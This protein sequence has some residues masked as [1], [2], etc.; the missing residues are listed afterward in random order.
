MPHGTPEQDLSKNLARILRYEVQKHN[1]T[2][3]PGGWIQVHELMQK[4]GVGPRA[5]RDEVIHVAKTS[6]G[7]HG[8]RFDLEEPAKGFF[9]IRARYVHGKRG[10]GGMGGKGGKGGQGG[11][12]ETFPKQ[13]SS[14]SFYGSMPP[15]P[16]QTR[17]YTHTTKVDHQDWQTSAQQMPEIP[18]CGSNSA[19]ASA[20]CGPVET[21]HPWRDSQDAP[22]APTAPPVGQLG[23]DITTRP[24]SG[25]QSFDISTPRCIQDTS[26]KPYKDPTTGRTWYFNSK[27]EEFFFA[28]TAAERGWQRYESD[29]GP[30]WHNESKE[31]WFWEQSSN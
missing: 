21:D 27:T 4:C 22:E 15:Q 7:S 3:D 16:A 25:P 1:L 11:K 19:S 5:S 8:K 13:D 31:T 20:A 26:W 9:R 17:P 14:G 2:V 29:R 18:G 12:G 6:V 10:K 23:P 30:W 28:D 24:Q